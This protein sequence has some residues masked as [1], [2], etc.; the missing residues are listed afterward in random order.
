MVTNGWTVCVFLC[1]WFLVV[2]AL[3]SA[4]FVV[5]DIIIALNFVLRCPDAPRIPFHS[6]TPPQS[7]V[8][9][10][11]L[12]NFMLCSGPQVKFPFELLS[13]SIMN[14]FCRLTKEIYIEAVSKVTYTPCSTK[15]AGV[16]IYFGLVYL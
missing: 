5:F 12:G 4:R 13:N 8:P 1:G 14:C 9:I 6:Y 2:D 15:L 3:N 11:Q 10:K 16:R 7:A